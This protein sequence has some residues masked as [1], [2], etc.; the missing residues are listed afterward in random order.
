MI[1]KFEDFLR[2]SQESKGPFNIRD[3]SAQNVVKIGENEIRI[4]ELKNVTDD[5]E[6]IEFEGE[7][8][9]GSLVMVYYD[10]GKEAY[11]IGSP[12]ADSDI[13]NPDEIK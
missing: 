11:V 4:T 9:D 1:L 5:G 10:N 8:S 12:G 2:E 13:L 7:M 6:V 3:K